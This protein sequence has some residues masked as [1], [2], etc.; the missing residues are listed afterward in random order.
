MIGTARAGE[1]QRSRQPLHEH[2]MQQFKKTIDCYTRVYPDSAI[3]FERTYRVTHATYVKAWAGIAYLLAVRLPGS[4]KYV[5]ETFRNNELIECLNPNDIVILGGRKDRRACLESGYHFFWTGGIVASMAIALSGRGTRLL[6]LQINLVRKRFNGHKRYFLLYEDTLPV[7]LFFALLG[8]NDSHPTICIE[9]G[10]GPGVTTDT[11]FDGALCRYNVLYALQEKQ[12]IQS[13]TTTFF[14][15][16]PPFDVQ[17]SSDISNEVILVGT[18]WKG[19]LP[20]FYSKSLE[21]YSGIE[22]KLNKRGWKVTYRP[23]PNEDASG[24]ASHFPSPDKRSKT[25]CLSSSRKIFIGYVSTLLYEAKVFGHSVITLLDPSFPKMPFAPDAEVDGR[26]AD[27]VVNIVPRLRAEMEH[28]PA[29]EL[30]PVRDRFLSL[31][32][33]IERLES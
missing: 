33:E 13:D 27:D 18:G 32:R 19:L 12:F 28:R 31:L 11:V 9:H 30:P 5:F 16:G 1:R 29:H 17:S 2:I 20:D 23:H 25:D 21:V 24:Y 8:E 4:R 22:T 14:E 26:C 7:G 15:L 3:E 6:E 10:Y